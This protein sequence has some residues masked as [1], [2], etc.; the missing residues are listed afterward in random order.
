MLHTYYFTS[1]KSN[2]F[3][4][5]RCQLYKLGNYFEGGRFHRPPV[6]YNQSTFQMLYQG[7]TEAF[8]LGEVILREFR[9]GV[10]IYFL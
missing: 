4:L 1:N 7:Y 5:S 3:L 9:F 2:P 8:S 6:P 10:P